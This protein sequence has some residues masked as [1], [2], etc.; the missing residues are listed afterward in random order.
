[1]GPHAHYP[2]HS[3]PG[4]GIHLSTL[5]KFLIWVAVLAAAV[6]FIGTVVGD[7]LGSIVTRWF[8]NW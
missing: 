4:S 8:R 7:D 3:A 2:E 6:W 5:F 1:M